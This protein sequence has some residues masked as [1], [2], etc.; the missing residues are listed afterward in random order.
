MKTLIT[1]VPGWLGNRLVEALVTDDPLKQHTPYKDREIRCL[2]LPSFSLPTN[3]EGKVEVMRG[4]VRD[5]ES[6][7][8]AMVGVE[9]VIHLVGVI[10]PKR[11]RDFYDINTQGTINILNAAVHA[12][13]R[14][15]VSISS[16]SPAG[17]NESRDRLFREEDPP[18][19]YKNYG[20]SKLL[21]EESVLKAVKEKKIE[22]VVLRPCWFYGPGQPAR[23]TRFFTMIKKGNPII[24]GDGTNLRSMSYLDNSIQGILL[25]EAKPQANGQVYWI[26]DAHPHSTLEIYQTVAELLGA[27]LRPRFI[28]GAACTLFELA[29]TLLQATGFYQQE[30]HVAGEMNKNIACSIEKA[31]RELGYAPTV[32]LREGMRRSIEWCRERNLL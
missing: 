1:G 8:K 31:Q 7:A 2:V 12:G 29:D 27:K 28:P 9:T 15:L 18:R 26:A 24:F 21:G 32:D 14:R 4:D 6:V 22:A 25:A 5:P 13:V 3:L 30:I 10:H 17:I 23:Q 19:P 11:I 20:K 16:N